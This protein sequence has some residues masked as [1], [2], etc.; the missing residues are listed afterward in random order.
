MF[1]ETAELYDLIYGSFKDY[2]AESRS[3]AEL[4]SSIH[5]SARSILDVACGT[6]EHACHLTELGYVVDGLDLEPGFVELARKKLPGSRVWQAD[7][8]DFSLDR[9]Y[10]VVLCLFSAIG[11]LCEL[12]LVERALRCFRQHLNP[13][14]VAVVEP[15]FEPEAWHPGRFFLLT[16]ESEELK[17]ARMSYSD[18]EGRI[19]TVKFHYLIGAHGGIE[20][21]EELHRLGL[22]TREELLGCFDRAGFQSVRHEAEGLSGRGIYLARVGGDGEVEG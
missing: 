8:A 18:A 19:S 2:L 22:Y 11:Y 7:M 10:D 20:H 1:S 13:G 15:W 16:A 21:R 6:G 14:G 5:P 3:I 9:R 17:V 12:D 4:L